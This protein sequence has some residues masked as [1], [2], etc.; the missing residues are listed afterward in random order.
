MT[1][2]TRRPP[3]IVVMGV[4]AAG[5]STVAAALAARLDTP[6]LDADDLHPGREPGEDGGG[7]AA[8]RRVIGGP[9]STWWGTRSASPPP[10][11]HC[12]RVLALRR[13]YRD[14]LR[15]SAH[16]VRF[17]HLHGSRELLLSRAAARTDHFMPPTLLDSQLATLE[18]LEDDETG[19]V[20]DVARRSTTFV[21]QVV[22]RPRASC[23]TRISPCGSPGGRATRIR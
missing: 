17:L 10:R 3:L 22:E 11:R 8:R 5:K 13:A 4:S 12:H 20:A 16:G 7:S 21:R 1:P 15:A 2:S 14:H 23:L 19:M 18:P 6:L 9:G